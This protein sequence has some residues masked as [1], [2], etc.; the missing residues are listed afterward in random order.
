MYTDSTIHRLNNGIAVSAE[1]KL[2]QVGV[3]LSGRSVRA[4]QQ[5]QR[6]VEYQ[7]EHAKDQNTMTHKLVMKGR[8]VQEHLRY[9]S[10]HS[11]KSD[12]SKDQLEPKPSTK[13]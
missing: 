3:Q 5:M 12:Y 4:L 9:K 1:E 13:P 6:E 11:V 8:Q 2:E 7:K 10:S